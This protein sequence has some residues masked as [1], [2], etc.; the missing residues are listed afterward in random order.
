[1][2]TNQSGR[3]VNAAAATEGIC[4]CRRSEIPDHSCIALAILPFCAAVCVWDAMLFPRV[5]SGVKRFTF[6]PFSVQSFKSVPHKQKPNRHLNAPDVGICWCSPTPSPQIWKKL[7]RHLLLLIIH[8][9]FCSVLPSCTHLNSSLKHC[10]IPSQEKKNNVVANLLQYSY[11][12]GPLMWGV[13]KV[14]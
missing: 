1:M 8:L 6:K 10:R 7:I 5:L 2:R 9:A 12:T 4:W 3:R 13:H 11:L 14:A